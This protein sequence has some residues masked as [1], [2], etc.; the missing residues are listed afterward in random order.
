MP[1]IIIKDIFMKYK[2]NNRV[3]EADSN[4]EKLDIQKSVFQ[5]NKEMRKQR[6]EE[7]EKQQQEIERQHAEREK[8]KR[9]AYERQLQNERI[10]LMRMKQGLI[11]ESDTIQEEEP[12]E[13]IKLSFGKKIVNFFY[14]NKWWLGLGVFF[15]GL[16]IFLAYD[17]LSKPNPDMVILMLCPNESVSSSTY[18]EDYLAEFGED[19]NKNGKVLVSVYYIPY[20]DDEYQNYTKGVTNKLTTFLNNAEGVVIIG[21]KQTTEDLLIPSESLVDLSKIYPDNPHV[22]DYYFYLKDTAFAER[23]GIP[24]S[25]IDDDLFFAIRQPKDIM[26]ASKEDM[27]ETYDQ[28]F[29]VFDKI[30][31]DLT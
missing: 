25:E 7:L 31:N 20:S 6:E 26:D 17:L 3:P 22:K 13:E 2:E 8:Q 27:Q 5:V 12:P 21:N 24:K 19:T 28:D 14:H 23:L 15:V 16:V 30:V 9:E 11:E 4:D 1:P 10:E 29:P 18:L